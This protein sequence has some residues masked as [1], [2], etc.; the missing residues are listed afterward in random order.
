MIEPQ[1]E[2]RLAL[3]VR[4]TRRPTDAQLRAWKHDRRVDELLRA[5]E[6]EEAYSDEL[7]RVIVGEPP[8]PP[9]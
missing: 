1:P 6:L 7:E 9:R 2:A 8:A 3:P 5:L 4:P